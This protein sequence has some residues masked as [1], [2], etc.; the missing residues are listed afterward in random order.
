MLSCSR[1]LDKTGKTGSRLQWVNGIVLLSTFFSFRL[2]WGA[3]MVCF[4]SS[5]SFWMLN[6]AQSYDFFVTLNGV[7]TQLPLF[8]IMVFGVTNLMLQGL[9]WFW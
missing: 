1:F 5:C 2:A 3:K 4:K 9:N 6:V 7:Y 8:Y